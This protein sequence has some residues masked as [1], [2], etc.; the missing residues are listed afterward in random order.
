MEAV[1]ERTTQEEQTIAMESLPKF[2]KLVRSIEQHSEAVMVEIGDH[3]LVRVALPAKLLHMIELMLDLMSKGKAFSLMPANSELTTQEAADMLNVSRPFIVKLL[4]EKA[5]GYKQV[6]THRRIPVEEL[7]RYM[8]A[9]KK[10]RKEALDELSR[11]G[12]EYDM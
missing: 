3:D 4:K 8:A 7:I 6:G 10:E 12:Q 9:M 2:N 5:M 11:L 1:L